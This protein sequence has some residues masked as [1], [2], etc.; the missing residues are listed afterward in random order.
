MSRETTLTEEK[1]KYFKNVLTQT[2]NA[3][4][5]EKRQDTLSIAYLKDESGD[6]T[7]RASLDIDN[8]LN[9]R[10]REREGRLI[11]KIKDALIRL[12]NGT[13]GICEECGSEI[14]EK[15]L[16][17]RPIARLCIRCKEKE[18]I[19]EEIGARWSA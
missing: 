19:A 9:L 1:R 18:E 6:F 15:R 2:L 13:F 11:H 14:P 12:E 8:T 16:Q 7:D 4:L 3:V 5:S 10:I 17:V